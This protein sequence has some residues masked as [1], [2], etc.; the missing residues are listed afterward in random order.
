MVGAFL[1]PTTTFAAIAARPTWL[2]PLILWTSLSFLVG[3]IV[4]TR[5]DWGSVI[6]EGAIRRDQKLTDA[7]V[8]DAVERSR[9]FA[10]MFEAFAAAAPAIIATATAAALWLACQAFGWEVAFRQSLGITL[11]AFLPGVVASLVLLAMLWNRAS[12]DPQ[13]VADLLPTHPGVLVDARR[14]AALHS[15][16]S[17]LD[18]LSF[19]TMGLLVLGLSAAA[20]APRARVAALVV[21]LWG[22]YAL[23]K[24]GVAAL[25]A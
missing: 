1:S 23:G 20:R 15:L 7:Q 2:A 6:R 18:V 13:S 17:S 10:W 3:E 8:E 22:L 14:Q 4:V 9:R 24:A 11:H 25:F 19:W 5:T 12:I 21:T 16:L